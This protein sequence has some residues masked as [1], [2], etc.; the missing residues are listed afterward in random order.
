MKPVIQ[1]ATNLKCKK[2]NANLVLKYHEKYANPEWL[3]CPQCFDI[4]NHYDYLELKESGKLGEVQ[5]SLF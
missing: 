3:S 2:C 5:K 4:I 1:K